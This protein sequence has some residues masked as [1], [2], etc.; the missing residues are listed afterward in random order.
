[1]NKVSPTNKA[2]IKAGLPTVVEVEL[3]REWQDES[4]NIIHYGDK[5]A[6][7]VCDG[8][9]W[10]VNRDNGDKVVATAKHI[11]EWEVIE[12]VHVGDEFVAEKD[13]PVR[14]NDKVAF[15]FTTN[16]SFVGADLNTK[17]SELTARVSWVKEWEM[18][19]LLE[20]PKKSSFKDKKVRYGSW[21]ALLAYNGKYVIYEKDSSK[22]LLAFAPHIDEWESY[23]FSVECNCQKARKKHPSDSRQVARRILH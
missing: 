17:N 9:Y 13:R 7:R 2:T 5:I 21:F 10:Q 6:I 11:K 16:N 15:R 12:I 3:T 22:Q 14:H 1:M 8:A 18:F 20:H 19:T 4:D 23:L